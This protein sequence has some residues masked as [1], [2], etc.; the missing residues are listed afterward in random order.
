MLNPLDY[1]YVVFDWNG[2][3][4]DDIGLAVASVNQLCRTQGLFELS[5]DLYRKQFCFPIRDFYAKLGFD[6]TRHSFP[7]LMDDYLAQFD[8]QVGGCDLCPGVATLLRQLHQQGTRISVLSASH[9]ETLQRTARAKGVDAYLDHVF[10]LEASDA[11]G[12]LDR[13]RDLDRRLVRS[14]SAK[15]LLIGDTDHD[16][17]VAQDCGWDFLA[18]ATGHQSVERLI[19]LGAPVLPSL[20][21]LA[22]TVDQE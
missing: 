18:V 14:A 15:V 21:A 16:A 6:F 19:G 2:T 8:A 9:Q 11:T 12:K 4:I 3:I 10:G 7:T 22:L 20:A 17:Q 1:A 13:A 5:T